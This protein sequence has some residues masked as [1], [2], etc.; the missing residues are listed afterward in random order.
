M[1][2]ELHHPSEPEVTET[3]PVFGYELLRDILIPGLLGKDT[4]EISYWAGK[5]LARKFP[6]LSLEEIN[7]FFEE[8]G[9]GKMLLLEESKNELKIELSGK[10]VLRRFHMLSDP[11]FRLEAGFIAEQIQ[12]QKQTV[13]EAYDEVNKKKNKVVITVRWDKRDRISD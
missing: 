10:M 11:C 13:T 6:L 8:A 5:H 7:S 1:N 2:Q 9:W 3:V 4:A 12:S